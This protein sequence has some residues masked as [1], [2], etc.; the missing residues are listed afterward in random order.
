MLR[1]VIVRLSMG[2]NQSVMVS[3][4]SG[5]NINSLAKRLDEIGIVAADKQPHVLFLNETKV[6]DSFADNDLETED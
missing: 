5:L 6:D 3:K 1:P 4:F 2:Q